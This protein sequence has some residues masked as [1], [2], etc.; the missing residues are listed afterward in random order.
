VLAD[1]FIRL[2]KEKSRT[3]NRE[4]LIHKHLRLATDQSCI[5]YY[6]TRIPL[7]SS[8]RDDEGD[9]LSRRSPTLRMKVNLARSIASVRDIVL[10]NG[11]AVPSLDSFHEPSS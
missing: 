1:G 7:R 10:R 6:H 3:R 2:G 5:I 11:F 9:F 8:R 4:S